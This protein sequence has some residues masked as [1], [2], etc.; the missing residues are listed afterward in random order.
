MILFCH[1]LVGA[2]IAAKIQILPLALI[3]AFLSHYVLDFIPH[4]EYSID[5]IFKKQWKK[6]KFDFLKIS[7]D[8]GFGILLIGLINHISSVISASSPIGL[9]NPILL[10]GAFFAI[11]PDGFTLLS[12]LL[13]NKVLS[14]HDKFHRKLVHRYKKISFKENKKIFLFGIFTQISVSILAILFLLF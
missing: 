13:P 9:I 10:V 12:I 2:A 7:L 4:W 5:N 14:I 11:L 8:F 6:A 1:L 3:F